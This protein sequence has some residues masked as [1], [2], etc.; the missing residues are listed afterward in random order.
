MRTWVRV[1]I[2]VPVHAV[3]NVSGEGIETLDAQLGPFSGRLTRDRVVEQASY[4]ARGD[5]D[6]F[7]QQFGK[8]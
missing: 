6:G 5:T 4:L 3:S 7:E 2:A 1:A 8:L